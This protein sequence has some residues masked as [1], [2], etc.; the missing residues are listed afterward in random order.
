M[1]PRVI[2]HLFWREVLFRRLLEI[3]SC[4]GGDKSAEAI[5]QMTKK[6]ARTLVS[7]STVLYNP[8][9][10]LIFSFFLSRISNSVSFS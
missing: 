7:M 5:D 9:M 8:R 1:T 6:R 4:L 2:R 3:W 10:L